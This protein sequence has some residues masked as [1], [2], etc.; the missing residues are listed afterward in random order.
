LKVITLTNSGST[1]ISLSRISVTPANGTDRVIFTA[2]SLCGSTL[3]PGR[4]CLIG[5]LMF[6]DQV[7]NLSALLNVP[8]SAVGSPQA[9]PLS[10]VV[11]RTH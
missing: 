4:S 6:A 10:V 9:V 5:V 8:N 1:P 3:A 11:T 2:A 7:G